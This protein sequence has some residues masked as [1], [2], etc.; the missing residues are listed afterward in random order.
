L[1][2]CHNTNINVFSRRHNNHQHASSRYRYPSDRLL[3]Q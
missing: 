2:E 1:G 3:G